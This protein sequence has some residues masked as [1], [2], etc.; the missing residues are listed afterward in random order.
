MRLARRGPHSGPP[1]G[2]AWQPC[3]LAPAWPEVQILSVV[4]GV[5][6][7]MAG[8]SSGCPLLASAAASVVPSGRVGVSGPWVGLTSLPLMGVCPPNCSSST[9]AGRLLSGCPGSGS[10]LCSRCPHSFVRLQVSGKI[11]R[12]SP[13]TTAGSGTSWK[14]GVAPLGISGLGVSKAHGC[15]QAAA[16]ASSGYEGLANSS[17]GPVRPAWRGGVWQ[18]GALESSFVRFGRF[19]QT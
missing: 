15:S 2:H 18:G 4:L 3:E 7:T 17:W 14:L 6:M 12:R 11:A 1:G 10:A 16:M 9:G 19:L 13:A 5:S 8:G